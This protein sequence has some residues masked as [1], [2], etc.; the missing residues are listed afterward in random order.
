MSIT[1]AAKKSDL[2]YQWYE[3]N[4]H[5]IHDVMILNFKLFFFAFLLMVFLL[6]N[7]QVLIIKILKS[8][9]YLF[10]FD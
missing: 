2:I 4:F 6:I 7:D 9:A 1:S 8:F 3:D 5:N 10:V